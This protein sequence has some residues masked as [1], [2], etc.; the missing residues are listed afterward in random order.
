MDLPVSAQAEKLR[1]LFDE[2]SRLTKRQIAVRLGVGPRQATRLVEDLRK[3]GVPVQQEPPHADERQSDEPRAHRYF[4]ESWHQR[5]AFELGGLDEEALH[6]LV[7]AVEAARGALAGTGYEAPLG[8]AFARLLGAVNQVD[9]DPEG[10][11]AAFDPESEEGRWHFG[12]A[13][14]APVEP[15]VFTAVSHALG[16]HQLRV[17]YVKGDGTR[18]PN[19]LLSPLGLAPVGGS[20][21]LAAYCHTN[22]QV[23]DFNVARLSHIR[24]QQ[25][26]VLIPDGYDTHRHFAGRFGGALA[27]QGEPQEVRLRVAPER[28]VYFETKRYHPSQQ[29]AREYAGGPLLVT[30]RVRTLDPVRAFVASWGPSV[31]A[32]APPALADQ[33][34]ADA[35]A[36]ATLYG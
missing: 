24:T 33:L 2:S 8:R 4:L 1:R 30:Y 27:G 13:A 26:D 34:R 35:Q 3:A 17:D 18:R 21:L 36:T 14:T 28:A 7:V 22:R 16:R 25:A 31:V 5:R 15:A 10:G 23:R 12:A 11:L 9:E 20:W 29:A 19:R 32:L 6:A